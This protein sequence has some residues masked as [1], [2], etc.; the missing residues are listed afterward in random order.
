M[1]PEFLFVDCVPALYKSQ[2]MR[3]RTGGH[4]AGHIH[5]NFTKTHQVQYVLVSSKVLGHLGLA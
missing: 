2:S 1:V 5:S 3:E 4:V